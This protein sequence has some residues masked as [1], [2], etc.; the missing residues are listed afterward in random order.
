MVTHIQ[1]SNKLSIKKT[2]TK[3]DWCVRLLAIDVRC[4]I[5]CLLYARWRYQMLHLLIRWWTATQ[6]QPH[7]W[8]NR[9]ALKLFT[10]NYSLVW[11]VEWSKKC[12]IIQIIIR[13]CAIWFN[14]VEKCGNR[15]FIEI[16]WRNGQAHTA[17]THSYASH[18]HGK[19]GLR[20]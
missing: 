16:H 6:T 5:V 18:M 19:F 1:Y 17:R 14:S 7:Q 15:F 9:F 2:T 3:N 8:M 12:W 11:H 4:S 13:V 10:D 20:S